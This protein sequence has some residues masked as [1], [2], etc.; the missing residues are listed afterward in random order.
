VVDSHANVLDNVRRYV[1]T[2]R[3]GPADRLSLVHG[4]MFSGL[5]SSLC[6][7]LLTGASV[8]PVDVRRDGLERLADRLARHD[9]TMLHLVPSLYRRLLGTARS[10]PAVRVVRLEG[11]AATWGDVDLARDRF[12][13]DVVVVNGLG[14]TET[15]LV[16]QWF[17]RPGRAGASGGTMPV[18]YPVLGIAVSL[19][20]EDGG[21]STAGGPGELV[22]HGRH[23]AVG[24]LGDAERT[25]SRFAHDE[26]DPTRRTYRTGDLARIDAS[27]SVQ[28]IGR[29]DGVHKVRGQTVDP[30]AVEERLRSLPGVTDA[31][32]VTRADGDAEP[33]LVAYAVG[34]ERLD[35][36]DLRR[37]LAAALPDVLVPSAVVVLPAMPLTSAGKLDRAALPAPGRTRPDLDVPYEAARDPLEERLAEIWAEVLDLRPIGMHDPFFDLGGDSLGAATMLLEVG[38]WLGREVPPEVLA[39]AATVAE[40]AGQLRGGSIDGGA[41]AVVLSRGP[42]PTVF[43]IHAVGGQPL[44]FRSVAR[45]FGDDATVISIQPPDLLAMTTYEPVADR[46]ARYARHVL[47]AQPEGPYHL[48]GHCFGGLIA[49]EL[50]RQLR[51]RGHEVGTVTLLGVGPLEFPALVSPTARRRFVRARWRARLRLLGGLDRGRGTGASAGAIAGQ[52]ARFVRRGVAVRAARLGALPR[53]PVDDAQAIM[54]FSTMTAVAASL[55]RAEPFPGPLRVVVG[56][57]AGPRYLREPHLDLARLATGR[58]SV[59]VLP[60]DDHAMLAPPGADGLGKALRSWV[61]AFDG[62]A[63]QDAASS[64]TQDPASNM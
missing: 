41:E 4:P 19:V 30:L 50:A 45:A 2:L 3:I 25:A 60:G 42:G 17:A 23:L 62:H 57:D 64:S 7:A 11:D 18:G 29:R 24:Y 22:V 38:R 28:V 9:A 6:S 12:A 34:D 56:R 54:D 1:D 59:T 55:H 53:D 40:L 31:V 49:H 35:G 5:V 43:L 36:P 8:I 32:A 10:W 26:T 44:F 13:S 27:G 63:G 46:A 48:V 16:A 52:V 51:E 15:G 33:R 47:E 20:H 61:D 14:T 21:A 37:A 58:V 39:R